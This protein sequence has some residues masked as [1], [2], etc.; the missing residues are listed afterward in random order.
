MEKTEITEHLDEQ[1]T[2]DTIKVLAGLEAVRKRPAMYIGSTGTLGLHHLVYEI[3][4]NSIDE[5]LGGFCDEITVTIHVDNSVTVIDNGR[6]IP[7]DIHTETGKSAAEVVLTILHAGGKFDNSMYKVSGGLHGVGVSVVNALSERL[8][9]EIRREGKV[10]SQSY[11]RGDPLKPLEIIGTTTRRGTKIRFKPDPEIF[12]EMEFAYDIL[13]T[14]LRELSFLNSGVKIILVDEREEGKRQEFCYEGGIRSFVEHLNRN[15]DPLHPPIYISGENAGT[16]I[17]VAIQYNSGYSEKV[18]SFANNINT[19]EGG[20]HLT[21]FRS[22]L[23]RCLNTY[24]KKQNMLKDMKDGLSG[25]DVKAGLT[26]VV[27]VKIQNPQFEGQTKT[28]LGNSEVRGLADNIINDK[29]S[30]FLEEN[31]AIARE[32]TAKCIQEARAR[33][34]ARRAKE[35]TRRKSALDSASLPGKLADCQEKDPNLSEI[36]L[37]EGDSAG[38]S[39]KQGRDR[40]NQAILPLKGKILNVEKARPEKM[41]ANKEIA[42]LVT[43][44]GAGIHNEFDVERIRY[45]NIIIMTDADVDGSHI[46]TLL[47][48]F[49]Y[50]MMP[51]VIERGYLYLAQPPLFRVVKGKQERYLQNEQELNRFL[52]QEAVAD[53]LVRV[54]HNGSTYAGEQLKELMLRIFN[55]KFHV[56][57]LERRGYDRALLAI[58]VESGLTDAKLLESPD[59]FRPF[60]EL[61]QSK[62]YEVESEGVD[63]EHNLMCIR[64]SVRVGGRSFSSLICLDLLDS[65]DYRSLCRVEQSLEELRIGP[66]QIIKSGATEPLMEAS[67]KEQ[68]L[69]MLLEQGRRSLTI[70]RYKGLG[71]MNPQQLWETTMD[72]AKRVMLQ[73]KLDDAV[74]AEDIFNV[75]MGDNVEPRREFIREHALEVANLD[76]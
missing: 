60:Q 12:T 29:L 64:A 24:G 41:L 65:A 75:L 20:T 74:A 55:F 40:R 67:T 53:Y 4:D 57:R 43:A 32:V 66:F 36:Y 16:V 42:V 50:R 26:A 19:R 25:D 51:E 6:G 56:D 1:Y 30:S 63:P 3:V 27:S 5:A 9:L 73:V 54:E 22:A 10:Y 34:A 49:F 37:V 18:F 72:P 33:D 62:G 59:A 8:D 68:L 31:P 38:G 2:A 76:I 69:Q 71:E 70:Q 39:A 61:L 28:K 15:A 14:R 45:R 11:E 7:V 58:L 21:G 52:V 35:L 44:L 17:E 46:R 23:T 47:L 48:T 13:A